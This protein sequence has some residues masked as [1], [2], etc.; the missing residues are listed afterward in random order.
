VLLCLV[1]LVPVASGVAITAI[2]PRCV[3]EFCFLPGVVDQLVYLPQ[4]E[5]EVVHSDWQEGL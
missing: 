5:L 3:I 4:T 2:E 1:C